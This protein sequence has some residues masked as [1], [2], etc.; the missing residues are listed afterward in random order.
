MRTELGFESSP[1]HPVPACLPERANRLP[2]AYV[3]THENTRVSPTALPCVWGL[4]LCEAARGRGWAFTSPP[5]PPEPG[6]ALWTPL[7]FSH[8]VGSLFSFLT[9]TR[10]TKIFNFDEV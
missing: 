10:C 2:R 8:S 5:R 3:C 9:L 7:I 4:E 1:P 6:R